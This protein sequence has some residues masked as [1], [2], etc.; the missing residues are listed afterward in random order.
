MR[1]N[2]T[3]LC[4]F[5]FA[6]KFN[7]SLDQHRCIRTS[8]FIRITSPFISH[9]LRSCIDH[10]FPTNSNPELNIIVSRT[11]NLYQ[12]FMSHDFK[13][14]IDHSTGVTEI[15]TYDP[16]ILIPLQF[17][18]HRFPV[19]SHSFIKHSYLRSCNDHSFPSN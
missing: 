12:T 7:A 11:Q 17:I 18:K 15:Q 16:S 6:S 2:Q 4:A 19:Q 5:I 8:S 10:S 3:K 14:C 9:E 13:S 1:S